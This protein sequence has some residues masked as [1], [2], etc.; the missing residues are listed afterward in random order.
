VMHLTT[1]NPTG[2]IVCNC[3]A[4]NCWHIEAARELVVLHRAVNGEAQTVEI[5]NL[6][7]AAF[8]AADDLND[9]LDY[10]AFFEMD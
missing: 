9:A 6:T 8:D 10:V 2:L 5:D 7:A 1:Y 3:K 4:A